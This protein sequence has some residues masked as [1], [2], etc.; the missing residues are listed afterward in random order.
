[1]ANNS[2]IRAVLGWEPDYDDLRVIVKSAL[3]WEKS[4][5]LSKRLINFLGTPKLLRNP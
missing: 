3:D 4:G 5:R 2:K 1:M